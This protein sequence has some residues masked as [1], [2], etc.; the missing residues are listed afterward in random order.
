MLWVLVAPVSA[1][2]YNGTIRWTGTDDPAIVGYRLYVR[3]EGGGERAPIEL[4]RPLKD[5]SGQFI[6][7]IGDLVVETTYVFTVSAYDA[8]GQEGGRSN[9]YTLGYAEAAAVVDSDHDGLTDA[10]EDRNGNMLRDGVETDR[11]EPDGDRDGVPDGVESDFGSDPFDAGSPSCASLDFSTLRQ[12][13][14]GTLSIAYDSSIDA[15]ALTTT[16]AGPISTTIGASYP[17]DRTSTIT[18]PLL[19]AWVRGGRFRIDVRVRSTDGRRFRLRYES[20]GRLDTMSRR[21]LRLDLGDYFTAG[22][23][24]PIGIDAAATI[25][26]MDPTAVFAS[27]ERVTVRGAITMQPLRAC[28]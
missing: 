23:Y 16:P 5:T 8:N 13:G 15:M 9:E 2:A 1:F 27:I 12:M 21:R 19:I 20:R 22:Q 24:D 4:A 26:A 28:H 17:R 7:T 18:D 25:A 11:L 6:G 3:P 14:R 10:E